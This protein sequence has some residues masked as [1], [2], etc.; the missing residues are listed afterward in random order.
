MRHLFPS[1][2]KIEEPGVAGT[3]LTTN[4]QRSWK[5]ENTGAFLISAGWVC[6]ADLSSSQIR[7]SNGERQDEGM[8]EAEEECEGQR[9]KGSED[10]KANMFISEWNH[11]RFITNWSYNSRKRSILKNKSQVIVILRDTPFI[12]NTRGKMEATVPVV[13]CQ[14]KLVGHVSPQIYGIWIFYIFILC[15]I[16][17][18]SCYKM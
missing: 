8:T 1:V 5:A 16:I 7:R 10:Y 3:I 18:Y 4:G 17:F 13:S 14:F 12:L 6:F 2:I 15:Y 9:D 11:H